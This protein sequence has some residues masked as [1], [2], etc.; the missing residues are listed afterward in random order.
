MNSNFTHLIQVIYQSL[1]F[2]KTQAQSIQFQKSIQNQGIWT[3]ILGKKTK[4]TKQDIDNFIIGGKKFPAAFKKNK[5][6]AEQFI[7]ALKRAAIVAPVWMLVRAAMQSV[8]SL[9][10]EQVKFLK[11]LETAMA[12]IQIVGK[13]TKEEYNDLKISLISLASA[14]GVS[15]SEALD[16][17]KIFA[18]QGRT[19]DE[20]FKL[21]RAAMIGVQVTGQDMK[22]IVNNLT[23]AIEG[24][25]V[26]IENSISIL[27]KWI[28]VER[29]FAVTS[30]DLADATKTAGATAHQ[31]GVSMNT[32]FGDVTAIVELTRKSGAQAANAL[33]FI[34]ARLLSTGKK[35]VEQIAQ[36]PYYLDKQGKAT[37]EVTNEYRNL[38]DI[39]GDLAGKWASFTEKQKLDIAL[40]VASKKQLT[41][42]LALM[43]NYNTSIEARI[44]ALDSAG[45]SEKAFGI[46][47]ETVAIKLE[48]VKTAWNALT[49]AVADTTEWKVFLDLQNSILLGL[50]EIINKK[51]AIEISVNKEKDINMKAI[52]TQKTQ[53][54]NLKE[55]ISLRDNYLKQPPKDQ[56]Q[57]ILDK[58]NDSIKRLSENLPKGLKIA[59]SGDMKKDLEG[60]EVAMDAINRREISINI[61]KE[62]DI[63]RKELENRLQELNNALFWNPEKFGREEIVSEINEIQTRLNINSKNYI[64]ELNKQLKIYEEQKAQKQAQL[65][66]SNKISTID[67]NITLKEAERLDI[68][69]QLNTIK[70]SGLYI[71]GQILDVEIELIK[72][73]LYLYDAHEKN[74]KL[75]ELQNQKINASAEYV[76]KLIEHELELAKIRGASGLE[77]FEAERRLKLMLYGE[78]AIND[79]LTMRLE[80]EKAIT[81]EKED[82]KRATSEEVE[83]MKIALR[84]GNAAAQEISRFLAGQRDLSRLTPDLQRIVKSRFGTAFEAAQASEFFRTGRGTSI[85]TPKELKT[86]AAVSEIRSFSQ[87]SVN[88]PQINVNIDSESFV[89]KVKEAIAKELE[90]KKSLI[91]KKINEIVEES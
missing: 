91:N 14:Y 3:D 15:A 68:E 83:L 33:Q 30:A 44:A 39:L 19:V 50:I 32:F 73:S 53:L 20:T 47:Q 6:A 62:F 75:A 16:A 51:K 48:K 45:A 36:I 87:V 69:K 34:Y 79:S 77:L 80:K 72:N 64:A 12:R 52:E 65:Q 31:L 70:N 90:N 8:F 2:E 58:L 71:N 9:I 1:G 38:S 57:T 54:E 18:Q 84:Y 82:Q 74:L 61:S 46:M 23:A 85:F 25:N 37:F 56:N 26:P 55:L 41:S 60:I 27:D 17:A 42:F 11:D 89:E 66:V 35:T 22:T 4:K 59:I 78:S 43:Q 7:L 40:Q 29:Q 81:Q 76:N 24:F 28:N 13:G 49:I 67:E 10:A 88:I 5:T 86:Q 63:K 21:T